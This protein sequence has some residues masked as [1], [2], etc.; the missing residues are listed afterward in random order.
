M[1]F[2]YVYGF[3]VMRPIIEPM[4]GSVNGINTLFRTSAPYVPGTIIVFLN[5]QAKSGFLDDGWVELGGD[6]VRLLEAPLTDDVVSAY[7]IVP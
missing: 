3:E 6:K 4:L 5:G 7:Y 1:Y 2:S